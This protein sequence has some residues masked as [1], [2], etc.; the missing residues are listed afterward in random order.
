LKAVRSEKEARYTL[1]AYPPKDR[2]PAPVAAGEQAAR[3]VVPTLK[4]LQQ[5]L[6]AKAAAGILADAAK[7]PFGLLVIA[8]NSR[9]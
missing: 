3:A 4:H 8:A 7:K 2:R 6:A 5:A 9:P 1:E